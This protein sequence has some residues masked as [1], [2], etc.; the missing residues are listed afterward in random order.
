MIYIAFIRGIN[1]GKKNWI[2]MS[3]LKNKFEDLG[4]QNVKTYI[5]SGNVIFESKKQ[6][7]DIRL[8]I[9]KMLEEH[10]SETVRTIIM[11]KSE[12]TKL[13]DLIPENW[14]ND[15]NQ[16][17]DVALLFPEVDKQ[18]IIKELP[19]I[20]ELIDVRYTKGAIFWNVK[21]SNVLKSRLAKIIGHKI[22]PYITI[23]NVNTIRSL[24]E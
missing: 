13:S 11:K 16:R 10:F 6:K 21:R 1:V 22:Y 24:S 23:R 7:N 5:N 4:Y 9:D 12:L 18:E 14:L 3:V 20:M 8:E 17:T 15:K 19:F 2:S